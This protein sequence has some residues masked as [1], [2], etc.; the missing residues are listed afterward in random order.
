MFQTKVVKK[1]ETHFMFNNFSS[2]RCAVYRLMWGKKNGRARQATDDN[3][4]WRMRIACWITK[5]TDTHSEYVILIAFDGKNGY[6]NAPQRYAYTYTASLV[7]IS[8]RS[9]V[10][11]FET[12]F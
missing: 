1:I 11:I 6:A 2:E 5:A 8:H 9:G 12:S 10:N 3:I 4:T 7:N